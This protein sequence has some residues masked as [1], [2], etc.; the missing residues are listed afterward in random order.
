MMIYTGKMELAI[1][2]IAE[3][4]ILFFLSHFLTKS[5]SAFFFRVTKSK[6]I[7]IQ[8]LAFLFLPGVIVHELAHLI[9]ASVLFV[10]TGEI[11]FLPKLRDNG[12]LKLGSVAI[13]KTDPI[14]RAVIGFAPVFVGIFIIVA[15]LFYFAQ[16]EAFFDLTWKTIIVFYILFEIGNTMFSSR[17][18]LEGTLE[19]LLTISIFAGVLYFAGARVDFSFVQKLF[20]KNLVLFIRQIDLFLLVPIGI[21]ILTVGVLKII[22]GRGGR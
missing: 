17:K 15:V 2:F 7:T 1:F 9:A 11:E 5:L 19:L 12:E 21:D 20:S 22:D 6:T 13:A 3:L 18:D 16:G 14:R 4:L 10:R 8:L